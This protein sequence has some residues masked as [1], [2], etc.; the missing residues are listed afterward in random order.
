MASLSIVTATFTSIDSAMNF[1]TEVDTVADASYTKG[2]AALYSDEET[3]S[4]FLADSAITADQT[5]AAQ[6]YSDGY[7]AAFEYSLGTSYTD[8]AARVTPGDDTGSA[9]FGACFTGTITDGGETWAATSCAGYNIA[10]TNVL[11]STE[12]AV[13]K[14]QYYGGHN[15]DP[16]EVDTDVWTATVDGDVVGTEKSWQC[17]YAGYNGSDADITETLTMTCARYLPAEA[18]SDSDDIRFD[19][20]NALFEGSILIMQGINGGPLNIVE[21]T[22]DYTWAGAFEAVAV[23]GTVAIAALAF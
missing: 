15:A 4:E 5:A 18:D 20:G 12:L 16:I 23:A 13:T 10:Y 2:V 6:G 21:A 9:I 19:G 14:V 7:V 8:E 17:S 3:L 22:G 1:V 11:S